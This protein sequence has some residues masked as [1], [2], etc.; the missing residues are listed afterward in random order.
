MSIVCW[1]AAGL[2][3]MLAPTSVSI[4]KQPVPSKKDQ[5]PIRNRVRTL[6]KVEYAT[7]DR[8][9]LTKLAGK[10]AKRAAEEKDDPV[11]R[12]VM[13]SEVVVLATRGEDI[14]MVMRTVRSLD[15]EFNDSNLKESVAGTL[16]SQLGAT[17]RLEDFRG[18]VADELAQQTTPEA[19][20][21][22]G[23]KWLTVAQA[24]RIESRLPALNRSRLWFSEAMASSELK[25][26]DRTA[27][28]K[29]W[30]EAT[31]N[32]EKLDAKAGRYSLYEGKWIVKYDN[33]YTH[34]YVVTAEGILTFD[35]LIA[36]DGSVS[37]KKEEQRGRLTRRAGV[38]VASFANGKV[39]ERF[40]LDVGKLIVDRFDPASLFPKSPN[41][42]GEGAREK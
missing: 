9:A 20:A 6:F 7:T 18:L 28:E 27:V 30:L 22:L 5:D 38:V 2:L 12:Y 10:L 33:K 39:L 41:N 15:Q 24:I 42:R 14:D 19:Q 35:R 31:A 16:S 34:E 8:I 17:E 26:L 36:P 11:T 29:G 40:S 1:A 25:G 23:K 3:F 21:R 4:D 37:T 32:I 13:L